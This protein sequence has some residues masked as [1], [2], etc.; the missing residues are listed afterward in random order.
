[1]T[2]KT[3][4]DDTRYGPCNQSFTPPGAT[5]PYAPVANKLASI[6]NDDTF[7]SL[8]GKSKHQLWWGCAR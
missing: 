5:Q 6:V 8:A 3:P 2:T 4:M 1:V 7:Q